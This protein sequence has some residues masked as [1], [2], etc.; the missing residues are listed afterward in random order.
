MRGK[1][2]YRLVDEKVRVF[3]APPIQDLENSP[4]RMPV[5]SAS[6]AVLTG[7]SRT[8]SCLSPLYPSVESLRLHYR[9]RV[10]DEDVQQGAVWRQAPPR[11]SDRRILLQSCAPRPRCACRCASPVLMTQLSPPLLLSV[12]TQT[13]D[14]PCR[15]FRSRCRPSPASCPLSYDLLPQLM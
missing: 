12:F 4:V 10:G 15:R 11:R 5:S 7:R 9:E 6:L 14:A 1:A 2:K 8:V 3:V 13:K